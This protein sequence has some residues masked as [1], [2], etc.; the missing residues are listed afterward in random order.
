MIYSLG[1]II[2]T[3]KQHPCGCNRWQIVRIGA[4]IKIKC[5]LCGRIVMLTPEQLNK[6][7]KN[8]EPQR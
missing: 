4:D 6:V 5:E 8:V 3:K 7:V 1:A 2:V